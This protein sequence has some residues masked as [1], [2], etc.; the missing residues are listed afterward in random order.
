M[1]LPQTTD[2]RVPRPC[3]FIA[4]PLLQGFE[5]STTT[6]RE[7]LD[8]QHL[9]GLVLDLSSLA[10][11]A[12]VAF[13]TSLFS[14]SCAITFGWCAVAD[15]FHAEV[16]GR[17]CMMIY[18]ALPSRWCWQSILIIGARG[19]LL[20]RKIGHYNA[21]VSHVEYVHANNTKTS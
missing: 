21:G 11:K 16:M 4:K 8:V 17:I 20:V 5:I 2:S 3:S 18:N 14:G 7:A 1:T 12:E 9:R 10:T 6:S 13:I 15:V 19:H